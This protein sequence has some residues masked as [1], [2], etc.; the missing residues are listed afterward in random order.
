M[1]MSYTF[2]QVLKLF[3][4]QQPSENTSPLLAGN[5][6]PKVALL[7]ISPASCRISMPVYETIFLVN[8][9]QLIM[10]Q[11]TK[12][13]WILCIMLCMISSAYAQTPLR[14]SAEKA[15]KEME[16]YMRQK[17]AEHKK[18]ERLQ[19]PDHSVFHHDG[20]FRVS[21]TGKSKV[22]VSSFFDDF[23]RELGIT[24]N[25]SYRLVHTEKDTY[26]ITHYAYNQYYKGILVEGGQ[27]MLHEK[28]ARLELANGK[29]Y[30]QISVDV[31]PV[32]NKSNAIDLALK[33]VPAT[34]YIWQNLSEEKILQDQLSDKK[35]SHYPDPVLVICKEDKT[36]KD[37]LA[38]KVHV[39]AET[40]FADKWLLLDAQ[41][42]KLVRIADANG[43]INFPSRGNTLYS[44]NQNFTSNFSN[45]HFSLEESNRPIRTMNMLNG[46]DYAQAA[47][48]TSR[49]F[50][51]SSF[52]T[53]LNTL[54]IERLSNAWN[55]VGE[56]FN[57]PDLYYEIWDELANSRIFRSVT[58]PNAITNGPRFVFSL[59]NITLLDKGRYSIRLFDEDSDS[60]DDLLGI[61]SFTNIPFSQ[62]FNNRGTRVTIS[63][64]L[65]TS[66]AL[67]AHWGMEKAYDYFKNKHGRLS[68]DGRNSPITVYLHVNPVISS[69]SGNPNN[70]FWD[71]SRKA[72]SI[73][74]GDEIV[75]GSLA[76]LDACAHELTHGVINNNGRGG[77]NPLGSQETLALNESFCDIFGK[78][79]EA[80]AQPGTTDWTIAEKTFLETFPPNPVPFLRSMQ[81]P[82]ITGG[83]TKYNG[84]NFAATDYYGKAGVQNRWFYLLANGGRGNIDENPAEPIYEVPALGL[85]K[86]ANIAYTNVMSLLTTDASY[87]DAYI[88]SLDAISIQGSP[89]PSDNY[90]TVREAWFAVGVA[91]RPV[92]N[93]FTPTQGPEG[94]TVS[95]NGSDFTGISYVGFNGTWVAAPNFTVNSD[96]T[97]I[98]VEVPVGATTGPI[99]LVAGYDT[100]TTADDFTVGCETPLTVNVNSTDNTSFTAEASGGTAPYTYS[101]DN[102]NFSANNVFGGLTSGATYTV[103]AKDAGSCEGETTFLLSNPL[104]C[105]VQAGSGGQGTSF[106]TQNL[107]QAGGE[108][109]VSYD[110]YGIPDQMEVF[111]D[112]QLLASTGGQ[113]SG[114]NSLTFT[115]TPNANGPFYCIIKMTAPNS[116]TAWE[117]IAFCPTPLR[118]TLGRNPIAK[119]NPEHAAGKKQPAAILFPNPVR[120]NA[121]LQISG[122]QEKAVIML[123]DMAGKEIWTTIQK[124]DGIIQVPSESLAAGVYIVTISYDQGIKKTLKLVKSN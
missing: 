43:H 20:L 44:G 4:Y 77:L 12:K 76:A 73:F 32:I 37:I 23:S 89:N 123:T 25:N 36:S 49:S 7:V 31:N 70:A 60:P 65:T 80:M 124:K 98:L 122:I 34:K 104:E 9:K 10:I 95:I 107:G 81:N 67:D 90:K 63:A 6:I 24:N 42:G 103:Y 74:D 96:Y 52:A 21:F 78:S 111:Y 33:T 112:N 109:V 118:E 14:T 26:G 119:N 13:R 45:L 47:K 62:R 56:D 58:V 51:W 85:D 2:I 110:M 87:K 1:L 68:Y 59:N 88:M 48:F 61:F 50:L 106:I 71:Y 3:R 22:T 93:T 41:N 8:S 75:Q 30:T 101:I 28:D 114:A 113:V 115:Y 54:T 72:I 53:K 121:S 57:R 17:Q 69:P 83:A 40:P 91:K 120:Q 29:I 84:V 116:G 15:K 79:T 105:N 64:S 55:G 117:F 39:R 27:L 100:V 38:Y 99:S 16:A 108:V 92:I 5:Y 86:A 11:T 18:H 94:E 82:K 97:Q 35:A 46:T 102:I 19:L 66:G